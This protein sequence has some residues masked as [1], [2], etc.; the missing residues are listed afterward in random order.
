MTAVIIKMKHQ[1]SKNT[2]LSS[3]PPQQSVTH[4]LF[5]S[6]KQRLRN[7]V[8]ERTARLGTKTKN[9]E[10]ASQEM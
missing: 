10:N 3:Q 2:S 4:M 8:L 6:R 5:T 7:K 1:S 9:C